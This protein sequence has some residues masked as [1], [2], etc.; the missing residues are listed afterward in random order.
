MF[1]LELLETHGLGLA[2][3]LVALGTGVLA[4]SILSLSLCSLIGKHLCRR[5]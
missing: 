1:L 3:V 2:V 4:V 5:L